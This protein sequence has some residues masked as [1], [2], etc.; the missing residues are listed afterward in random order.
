VT[1]DLPDI[2]VYPPGVLSCDTC[3]DEMRLSSFCAT[4]HER[5][6][7]RLEALEAERQRAIRRDHLEAK[8]RARAWQLGRAVIS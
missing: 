4:C 5:A 2:E 6:L 1:R 7:Q 8:R 3:G